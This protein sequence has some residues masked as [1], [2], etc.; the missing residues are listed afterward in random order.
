MV[1]RGWARGCR[2]GRGV[3]RQDHAEGKHVVGVF[4]RRKDGLSVE[5]QAHV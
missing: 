2:C 4:R 3:W 1:L 5:F